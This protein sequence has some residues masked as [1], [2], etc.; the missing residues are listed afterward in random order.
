MP[1][2]IRLFW[3]AAVAVD[4]PAVDL[5]E[6]RRFPICQPDGLAELFAAAGLTEVHGTA[7]T[8]ATRF[9]DS[10]TTGR[11]S[12]AARALRGGNAPACLTK[13]ESDFGTSS[14]ARCLGPVTA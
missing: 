7:V 2:P 3:D 8:V 10:T 6:G 14:A 9:R 1:A 12:S 11:P 13:R 4:P 5:D